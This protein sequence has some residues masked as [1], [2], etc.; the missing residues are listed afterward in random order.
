MTTTT[1]T[2]KTRSG[3]VF[4]L[5]KAYYVKGE[6]IVKD[7][8]AVGFEKTFTGAEIVG[9]AHSASNAVLAR[10]RRLGAT[11]AKIEGGKVTVEVKV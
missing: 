9:Y 11:L 3:A 6:M 10:A 5:V 2:I 8:R 4:A 1:V 7:G